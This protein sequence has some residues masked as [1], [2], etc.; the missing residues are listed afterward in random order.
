MGARLLCARL[1]MGV[2]TAS[3]K[4][5]TR[6]NQGMGIANERLSVLKIIAYREHSFRSTP[7]TLVVQTFFCHF[8]CTSIHGALS[9]VSS[10]TGQTA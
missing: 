2:G 3:R 1:R 8:H 9:F 5:T 4:R 10:S 7:L 6:M